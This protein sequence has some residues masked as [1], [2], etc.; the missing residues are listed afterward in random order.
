MCPFYRNTA[1]H[2][3]KNALYTAIWGSK[4][5]GGSACKGKASTETAADLCLDYTWWIKGSVRLVSWEVIEFEQIVL[6]VP[7]DL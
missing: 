3:G 2:E 7:S 5:E 6:S 4:E 1:Q